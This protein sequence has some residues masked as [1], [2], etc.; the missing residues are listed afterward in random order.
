MRRPSVPP[1]FGIIL[2]S[3]ERTHLR[4]AATLMIDW[5]TILPYGVC[6]LREAIERERIGAHARVDSRLTDLRFT[7]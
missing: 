3:P 7:K 2:K 5:L 4:R 1:P 6:E